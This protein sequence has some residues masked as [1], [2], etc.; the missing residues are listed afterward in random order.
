M[1]ADNVFLVGDAARFHLLGIFFSKLHCLLCSDLKVKHVFA[2]FLF[3]FELLEYDLSLISLSLELVMQLH[4]HLS[5]SLKVLSFLISI[6]DTTSLD[7]VL[8]LKV[9]FVRAPLLREDLLDLGVAHHLLI[10]EI[11]DA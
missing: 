1:L 6:C 3:F 10:F 11:L 5:L 8:E 2:L 9:F 4:C 7:F